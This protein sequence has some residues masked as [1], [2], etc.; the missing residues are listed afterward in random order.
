MIES[1]GWSEALQHDF[2]PLAAQGFVPARVCVQ[3][4][5][6][7]TLATDAGELN[8]RCSGRLARDALPGELPVVGDWVA[9]EGRPDGG[10]ATIHAVLA[11]R[12]AFVR[13]AVDSRQSP[14]VVAANIDVAF[15]VSALDGPLNLRRLE[16]YLVAARQSGAQPVVVLT[17]ADRSTEAPDQVT[18]AQRVALDAAVVAVSSV[19]GAGL[20][21]LRRWIA[22]G[23][24][25]ALL[26]VSGAGKSTLLNALAGEAVMGTGAVRENDARGRHTTT[27]R[28][29]VLLPGG[30]LLLDT[31]GMRELGLLDAE[32]GLASSFDDVESLATLCRF[33]GCRHEAEPGCAV[34]D[35]LDTG[36]LDP[37]RWRAWDKLR[38]E[39]A[40]FDRKDDPVA[41]A[42]ERRRWIAINKAQRSLRRSR[43][44]GS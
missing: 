34:R 4:R 33:R 18:A 8:G 9:I 10:A 32:E 42:N 19:T 24:T 21:E 31:P 15:L 1:F 14:Q 17:K 41:R 6:V 26:G 43:E 35:A 39:S 30:G 2:L 38:R 16:R 11:R 22:P 13:K 36:A 27:H 29:L 12:T 37:G 28:Q 44:D 20:D 25:C 40:H 23:V 5:S 7:Y 3:H